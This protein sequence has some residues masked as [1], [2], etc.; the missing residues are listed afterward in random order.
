MGLDSVTC[1]FSLPH[2]LKSLFD[3]FF[4]L[5]DLNFRISET[6]HQL[7]GPLEARSRPL[8]DGY[9]ASR[10]DGLYPIRFRFRGEHRLASLAKNVRV[11]VGRLSNIQIASRL[12]RRPAQTCKLLRYLMVFSRH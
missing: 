9:G 12:A 2:H 6:G 4:E 5:S 10:W 3:K 11:C 7:R 8:E 1:Q